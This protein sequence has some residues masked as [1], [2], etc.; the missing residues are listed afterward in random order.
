M[1]VIFIPILHMSK[2]KYKEV[3]ESAGS[4]RTVRLKKKSK[5][6]T[7]VCLIPKFTGLI[8]RSS[9]LLPGWWE[10]VGF[11]RRERTALCSVMFTHILC[12][13]RIPGSIQGDKDQT[14]AASR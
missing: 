12:S 4:H 2:Q 1:V 13:R 3:T 11:C 8:L 9:C 14:S 7:W 5:D 10:E 6:G